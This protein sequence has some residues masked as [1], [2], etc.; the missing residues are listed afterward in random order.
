[1]GQKSKAREKNSLRINFNK[2]QYSIIFGWC[3]LLGKTE[4]FK[5]IIE[6]MN[7]LRQEVKEKYTLTDKY[8][9]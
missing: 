4:M 8:I 6:W 7:K 1:M 9:V 5:E 3:F 2:L